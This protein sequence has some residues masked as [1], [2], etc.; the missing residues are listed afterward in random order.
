[1]SQDDIDAAFWGAD[2]SRGFGNDFSDADEAP[3]AEHIPKKLTKHKRRAPRRRA[4]HPP[5]SDDDDVDES[6]TEEDEAEEDD[7]AAPS[8]KRKP[9][10]ARRK[11]EQLE[12]IA[13]DLMRSGTLVQCTAFVD[14]GSSSRWWFFDGDIWQ[15]PFTT[16]TTP[17]ITSALRRVLA[18][19]ARDGR[20]TVP[21]GVTIS[22]EHVAALLM[23]ADSLVD[24]GA[25]KPTVMTA[26]SI[27][28]MRV[29][30]RS[31]MPMR[32]G[33]L[34]LSGEALT[35]VSPMPRDALVFA[36]EVV[37][38]DCPVSLAALRAHG[39]EPLKRALRAVLGDDW[40]VFVDL[41]VR[42]LRGDPTKA[43]VILRS[44]RRSTFKSALVA[45]ILSTALGQTRCPC[46]GIDAYMV[47]A[48]WAAASDST[49]NKQR[50][51]NLHGRSIIRHVDEASPQGRLLHFGA[52]KS[53]QTP[54]GKL[55]LSGAQA[56]VK[57]PCMPL[58]LASTNAAPDAIFISPLSR[59]EAESVFV[60]DTCANVFAMNDEALSAEDRALR[61]ETRRWF[62][63]IETN[64]TDAVRADVALQLACLAAWWLSNPPEREQAASRAPQLTL[65]AH[66]ARR[67]EEMK[68][69][70]N[71]LEEPL[72][73]MSALTAGDSLLVRLEV[74]LDGSVDEFV[75]TDSRHGLKRRDV[76]ERA[77]VYAELRNGGRTASS[78]ADIVDTWMKDNFNVGPVTLTGGY[79]G[80]RGVAFADEA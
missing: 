58:Y 70:R 80:Y 7:K 71:V 26:G 69:L 61:D 14:S 45:S 16:N 31:L 25:Q 62:L 39:C 67:A 64:P 20:F 76:Y 5:G 35:I 42:T 36:D 15:H 56:H 2:V 19:E 29:R 66:R 32:G 4:P 75:F 57:A 18:R 52:I 34:D 72:S 40:V 9:T 33:C 53:E 41:I 37:D 46:P 77:G 12:S 55:S 49:P 68:A 60:F 3:A 8:K 22:K 63:R 54:Y 28:A 23:T 79:T 74:W 1:M 51:I 13:A 59:E 38:A 6:E 48:K 10:A 11:K 47:G 21:T 17:A 27:T 78:A 50:L 73:G 30:S 43:L 65:N 24:A 44:Q